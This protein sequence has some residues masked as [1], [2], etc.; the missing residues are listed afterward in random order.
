MK[1]LGTHLVAVATLIAGLGMVSTARADWTFTDSGVADGLTTTGAAGGSSDGNK[2]TTSYTGLTISGAYAANGAGNTA[3]AGTTTWNTTTTGTQYVSSGA[4]L[5]FYGGGGLGMASDG[6]VAPNHAIDNNGNT[7]AVLL[8][9]ST[10]TILSQ[11]GLGYVSGDADISLF[12]YTGSS[13]PS[14]SGVKSNLTDMQA[15]GWELVGNYADLAQDVASPYNVVNSANKGSSWWLISAYNASYGTTGTNQAG[16]TVSV[17]EGNDYFKIY[18]VA[19]SACTDTSVGNKC[20]NTVQ[21]AVPEPTSLALVAIAG[22][23]ALSVRRR[24]QAKVAAA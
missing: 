11:I 4:Q 10:S 21:A 6:Q 19:G 17:D 23:G 2:A 22:L 7:E 20:G 1:K 8:S 18:V 16:S 15:A 14:L 12:R 13:A 9:F 5:N 24:R 3:F